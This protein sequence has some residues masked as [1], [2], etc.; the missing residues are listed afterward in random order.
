MRGLIDSYELSPM[1]AGMLFHAVSG[2]DT[3]VDV[4]EVIAT[5]C[6]PL[7]ELTGSSS[8]RVASPTSDSGVY[9]DD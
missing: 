9:M 6:E 7:E 4:E 8:K 2:G 1:Q 5:L 3:G